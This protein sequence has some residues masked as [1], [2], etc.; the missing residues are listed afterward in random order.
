MDTSSNSLK[1][2]RMDPAV[3]P[4]I[5]LLKRVVRLAGDRRGVTA[6]EYAILSVA[7]II[8]VGIAARQ[9]LDPTTGAYVYLSSVLSQTQSDVYS[10]VSGTR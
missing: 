10:G 8:V 1:A 6:A 2:K 9:L 3:Q 7:V 5:G 4:R